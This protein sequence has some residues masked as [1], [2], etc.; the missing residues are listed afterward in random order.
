MASYKQIAT[1]YSESTLKPS[2][3]SAVGVA[4][5]NIV[6]EAESTPNHAERYTWAA[7]AAQNP[8]SE[9]NRFIMPVLILNK[10]LEVNEIRALDDATV[11]GNVDLFIDV[12]ALYDAGVT[13]V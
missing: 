8:D 10:E 12:F 7:K 4:A 13:P 5:N 1:L 11:Q 6:F 9:A 2:I 3:T